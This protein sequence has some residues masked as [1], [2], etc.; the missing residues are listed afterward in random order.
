MTA[1]AGPVVAII[2]PT[3]SGKSALALVL[4]ARPEIR[5]GRRG[6]AGGVVINMDS[7]QVYRELP[8]ITAQPD[9][10]DKARVP[11]T[12]YG[13]MPA[14]EVGS[15]AR[16]TSEARIEIARAHEAGRLPILCGG[17]GLYLRALMDG[18]SPMPAVP[19]E[20]RAAARA[21]WAELGPE[22]F[23]RRLAARDPEAAARL[24]PNDRQRRVR[25]WEVVEATG[26]TLADWH[27][28]APGG[29]A[30][31]G[32]VVVVAL[33]SDRDWLRRRH[34]ERFEGM[35][36]AGALDEVA[37]LESALA[38]RGRVE[39]L[40]LDGVALPALKAHG[41]PELRAHLA[42]EMGLAAAMDRAV[43]NTGRYAKRQMTWIRHQIIP[44]ISIESQETGAMSAITQ[45]LDKMKT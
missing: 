31:G 7:M 38:A 5:V 36:A 34:R 45:Y 42:G 28:A 23:G 17:T 26:R 2:G 8:L 11:H 12:L 1:P 21:L 27:A 43:L 6:F 3:A 22:E 20:I 25:A 9:E 16:W 41:V 13:H 24:A 37:A 35:L 19:P 39:G 32:V 15:A 10:S 40:T 44:Q 33:T 14:W 4:A 29:T 18:L 30:A